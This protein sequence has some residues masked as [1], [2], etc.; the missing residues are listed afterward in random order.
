MGVVAVVYVVPR[1]RFEM[2]FDRRNDLTPAWSCAFGVREP[3]DRILRRSSCNE[4]AVQ[5]VNDELQTPI[6]C[7]LLFLSPPTFCFKE[8]FRGLSQGLGGGVLVKRVFSQL[9]QGWTV[10]ACSKQ[11]YI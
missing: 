3:T 11:E 9:T 6:L 8:Q 5:F 7:S 4:T 2:M 1:E 10:P